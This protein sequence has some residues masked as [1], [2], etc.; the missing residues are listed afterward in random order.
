MN[1][2]F[3]LLLFVPVWASPCTRYQLQ[4]EVRHLKGDNFQIVVNKDTKS[5]QKFLVKGDLA[6]QITPYLGKTVAGEFV[7]NK[8]E[9]LKIEK[10]ELTL[11][12]PL[13]HDKELERLADVPCPKK[14]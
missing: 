10:I 3:A 8:L 5:E 9:V 14:K 2:L 6:F 12:D 4:G 1:L 11:P 7:V 13:H